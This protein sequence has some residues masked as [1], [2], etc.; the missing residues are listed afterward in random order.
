[1]NKC[2]QFNIGERRRYA[3]DRFMQSKTRNVNFEML[4]SS[5]ANAILRQRFHN[6]INDDV[7]HFSMHGKVHRRVNQCILNAKSGC[8][9]LKA[10][11][12]IPPISCK[13]VH[14]DSRKIGLTVDSDDKTSKDVGLLESNTL[15]G[16]KLGRVDPRKFVGETNMSAATANERFSSERKQ[17]GFVSCPLFFF[18]RNEIV[19]HTG[20][21]SCPEEGNP[22]I[23]SRA[24]HLPLKDEG[25]LSEDRVSRVRHGS[26][27]V[28]PSRTKIDIL[29]LLLLE[30]GRQVSIEIGKPSRIAVGNIEMIKEKK[31]TPAGADM[32]TEKVACRRVRSRASSLSSRYGFLMQ[33]DGKLLGEVLNW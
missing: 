21:G 14:P 30:L 9:E 8:I 6:I 24:A 2:G 23:D 3:P 28:P 29:C 15:V 22:L 11:D 13:R 4:D 10:G 32:R 31:K 25:L 1:M 18:K 19:D 12:S 20:K 27:T 17:E 7:P 26:S 33:H 16:R 5:F